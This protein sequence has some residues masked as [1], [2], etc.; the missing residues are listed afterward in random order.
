LSAILVVRATLLKN[1]DGMTINEIS[2]ASGVPYRSVHRAVN[3]M[4]DVYIDRWLAPSG[5]YPYQ[6]VWCAI[7]VP[8]NCP[9]PREKK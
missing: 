1:S 9:H 7:A 8:N 6:A 5:A 4:E 3:K 2:A